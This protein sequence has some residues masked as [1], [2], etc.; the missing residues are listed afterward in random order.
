[1]PEDGQFRTATYRPNLRLLAQ[2]F[3]TK[4]ESYPHLIAFLKAHTGPTIVYVTLQKHTEQL[5]QNLRNHGFTAK[6]FHAG[7]TVPEKIACQEAFMASEKMIMVATIAFGMGIDKANIRNVVHYDVPRSLESYSQE[8]G[9]AGR[10]GE[11]SHCMLYLCAEDLHLRESFARGDLP[12]KQSV[13]ALLN[14]VFA[15]TPEITDR[16]LS[17]EGNMYAEAKEFDIKQTVLKNIYAQL[18]LR[19]D[20]LRETTPKYNSYSYKSLV[21]TGRDTTPAA[22]AIRAIAKKASSLTHIDVDRAARTN[23][24]S[25]NEIVAK[26]NAWHDKAYIDLRTSG[27]VNIYRVLRDLPSTQEEKSRII[28]ELYAELE[29]REHQDLNRGQEVMDLINGSKCFSR[30]LAQ[31]F[32]DGLPGGERNASVLR[33][34]LLEKF[35]G[36]CNGANGH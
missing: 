4:K 22:K 16:G 11:E 18:E 33:A 36:V 26:L 3:H 13:T 35:E 24:L 29:L 28:D 10:D 23:G 12:S 2:S 6:H 19:F 32:G 25:R 34:V 1:M 5:A 21:T 17:I 8:I 30:T 9:R 27:V 20:L 14:Q 7:M 31:H 15:K